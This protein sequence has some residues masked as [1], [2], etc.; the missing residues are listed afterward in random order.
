MKN[1]QK[2][3]QAA[4]R[5]ACFIVGLV[6]LS[7]IRKILD[8]SAFA[9]SVY[10]FHMLPNGMINLV[11]LYLPWLELLCAVCL[12]FVPRYRIA[13]LWIALGLFT[14]FSVGISINLFRGT[15][16]SCGCFGNSPLALPMNGM[17]VARNLALIL[18]I[19]LAFHA[20]RKAAS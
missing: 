20:Q 2:I 10:R 18:L 6:L 11:A 15:S 17:S 13:A 8:P 7:G 14:L 9:L 1:D 16:F 4:F 12:L 19:F 3:Y 5:I